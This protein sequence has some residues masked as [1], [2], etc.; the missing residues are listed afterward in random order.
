MPSVALIEK[1][2]SGA[3]SNVSASVPS[4]GLIQAA[5]LVQRVRDA[6]RFGLQVP[7][8][9]PDLAAVLGRVRSLGKELGR[10]SIGRSSQNQGHRL[11]QGSAAFDAY[12][13]VRVDGI[14]PVSG[15]KF[16]I[17]TGARPA[18]PAIPGLAEAGYL[19][20]NSLWSLSRL[21]AKVVVIGSEPVGIEF[22]QSLARFGA[23]VT[24]LNT[25]PRILAHDDAEASEL[26]TRLLTAEGLSI[27]SE[28]R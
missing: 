12:D 9:E 7:P 18:I 27:K 23:K 6:G 4:K 26:I 11:F 13:T 20:S 22:A 24:V 21:P 10:G 17:A 8:I 15:Q 14:T 19:D 1:D 25:A 2:Q 5:R 28:S 16:V 3:E